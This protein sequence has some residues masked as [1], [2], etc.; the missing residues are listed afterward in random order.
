M[1]KITK[2]IAILLS[3]IILACTFSF[4]GCGDDLDGFF[5]VA[6]VSFTTNGETKTERSVRSNKISAGEQITVEEYLEN[7]NNYQRMT[8]NSSTISSNYIIP[9]KYKGETSFLVESEWETVYAY[10]TRYDFSTHGY[11]V[12]FRGTYQ[13]VQYTI[14]YMK[15]VDNSTI[16]IKKRAET[17][18]TVTSFRYTQLEFES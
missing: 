5:P 15:V 9:K 3:A 16:I 11:N 10:R 17:T 7:P 6:N 14:I 2:P 1:Q 12:Y 4:F 8:K 13:G 18:Y